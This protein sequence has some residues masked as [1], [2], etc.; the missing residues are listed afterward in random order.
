MDTE[1]IF[2]SRTSTA[3]RKLKT[4]YLSEEYYILKQSVSVFDQLAILFCN[5]GQTRKRLIERR[6]N[7]YCLEGEP[8]EMFKDVNSI[9]KYMSESRNLLPKRPIKVKP[10][11]GKS[12][13]ILSVM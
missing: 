10:Q 12:S 11:Q 6:N 1:P 8:E 13:P 4:K 5:A 9:I 3:V 2:L 7:Q